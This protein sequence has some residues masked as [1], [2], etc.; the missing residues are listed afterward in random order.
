MRRQ[1]ALEKQS[2]R[3]DI[4]LASFPSAPISR[5]PTA[6]KAA[7]GLLQINRPWKSQTPTTVHKGE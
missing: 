3:T 2:G 5:A 4:P 6:A 7:G 1:L